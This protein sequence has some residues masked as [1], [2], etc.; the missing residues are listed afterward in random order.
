M[1]TAALFAAALL[2]LAAPA[3]IAAEAQP[4]VQVTAD[5]AGAAGLIRGSVDINATP[6]VVWRVMVDP[7][8]TARLMANTKSSRVVWRDPAGRCRSR[9]QP[10]AR[11]WSPRS[12]PS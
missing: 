4:S 1:T 7:G 6:A 5:S 2:S 3:A 12:T 8:S 11:R 10:G 9:T